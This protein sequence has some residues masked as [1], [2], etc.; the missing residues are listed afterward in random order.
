M[1]F[2]AR[3][4]E[5]PDDTAKP[6]HKEQ[7]CKVD[8]PKADELQEERLADGNAEYGMDLCDNPKPEHVQR[9]VIA[10]EVAEAAI[11]QLLHPPHPKALVTIVRFTE[12]AKEIDQDAGER[13]EKEQLQIF[14]V[15][16][17]QHF[18]GSTLE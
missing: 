2:P 8:R 6:I 12:S 18:R 17:Y 15:P 10:L 5:L 4:P 14:F 3:G 13:P 1:L 16:E 7:V 11:Y 9:R